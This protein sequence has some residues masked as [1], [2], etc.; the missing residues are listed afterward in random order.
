MRKKAAAL[1]AAV[2]A[3]LLCACTLPLN[4]SDYPNIPQNS[5]IQIDKQYSVKM[6]LPSDA[7]EDIELMS[8]RFASKVK[9]LSDGMITAEAYSSYSPFVDYIE[10]DTD[11]T[12]LT[13]NEIV[14]MIPS[15]GFIN[16][17]FLFDSREEFLSF[18]NNDE[19][20]VKTDSKITDLFNGQ[21]LEVYYLGSVGLTSRARFYPQILFEGSSV[22]VLSDLGQE[23]A[24]YGLSATRTILGDA[25]QLSLY[26]A[27]SFTRLN[28]YRYSTPATNEKGSTNFLCLTGHRMEG[29]WLIL[30]NERGLPEEAVSI[31]KEAVAYTV[32][33][34]KKLAFEREDAALEA[35]QSEG[36]IELDHGPYDIIFDTATDMYIGKY[37]EFGI[38]EKAFNDL[39]AILK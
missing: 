3:F 33:E 10:G 25:A 14:K 28:E 11:L 22:G 9:E 38:P 2:L 13:N 17:P 8:I 30:S 34:T 1:T 23:Q 20:Y 18:V 39:L 21:L 37:K 36:G 15:L 31:I 19:G 29:L 7:G 24:F 16:M 6:A 26:Q 4:T 32:E 27:G 5:K 12:L 35:I